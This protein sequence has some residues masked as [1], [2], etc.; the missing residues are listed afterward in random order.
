MR[1]A[2]A[3]ALSLPPRNAIFLLE[4]QR[5]FEKRFLKKL[6]VGQTPAFYN[7]KEEQKRLLA[8]QRA[9]TY[10]RVTQEARAFRQLLIASMHHMPFFLFNVK[11][12]KT[13]AHFSRKT[14]LQCK[15]L[16]T[17]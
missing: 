11:E 10:I 17:R 9:A 3:A 15:Y 6:S 8:S 13:A 12:L 14:T 16:F 5:L 7:A 4:T 1:P 2:A